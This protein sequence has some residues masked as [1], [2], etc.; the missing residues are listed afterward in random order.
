MANQETKEHISQ[1]IQNNKPIMLQIQILIHNFNQH[2]KQHSLLPLTI[3][4][5][6]SASTLPWELAIRSNLAGLVIQNDKVQHPPVQDECRFFHGKGDYS[7]RK[8]LLVTSASL[9]ALFP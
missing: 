4:L 9:P 8:G 2:G 1:S 7:N 5:G 3:S 6:L